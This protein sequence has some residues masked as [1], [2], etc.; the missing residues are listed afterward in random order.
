MENRFAD[1]AG[2]L[3]HDLVVDQT[4]NDPIFTKDGNRWVHLGT[5]K[6]RISYDSVNDETVHNTHIIFDEFGDIIAEFDHVNMIWLTDSDAQSLRNSAGP[7]YAFT[8][9]E[10]DAASGLYHYRARWYDAKTHQFL[11]EDPAFDDKANTYR[12]ANNDPVNHRDPS[13]NYTE[14]ELFEKYAEMYGTSG[15]ADLVASGVGYR[16]N[17]NV[18]QNVH[19]TTGR[20]K[21]NWDSM[22]QEIT[23]PGAYHWRTAR[24]V[25]DVGDAAR[26]LHSAI[27]E[28]LSYEEAARHDSMRQYKIDVAAMDLDAPDKGTSNHFFR[29]WYMTVAHVTMETVFSAPRAVEHLWVGRDLANEELSSLGRAGYAAAIVLDVTSLIPG[30]KALTSLG[31]KF[32]KG[33]ILKTMGAEALKTTLRNQAVRAATANFTQIM[34]SHTIGQLGS[35]S[36]GKKF[37]SAYAK[38]FGSLDQTIDDALVQFSPDDIADDALRLVLNSQTEGAG[39]SLRRLAAEEEKGIRTAVMDQLQNGTNFSKSVARRLRSGQIRY[40]FV[41]DLPSGV[42]GRYIE[43]SHVIKLN[44]NLAWVDQADKLASTLVHEARHLADDSSGLLGRIIRSKGYGVALERGEFRAHAE[45]LFFELGRGRG[46]FYSS[47]N[48]GWSLQGGPHAI[49]RKILSRYFF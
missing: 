17:L 8:G 11:S 49:I 24:G 22:N 42:A 26:M 2:S 23:I 48:E 31:S 44:S 39:G 20:Y 41:D 7:S 6:D 10:Y 25:V 4:V 34:G 30:A 29:S 46:E 16:W 5:V 37:L 43:G 47:W 3:G 35:S 36:V 21:I 1:D 33:V 14:A 45:Q 13:G 18:G 15:A 12:Y 27:G 38:T 9:R 40:R 32:A 19:S 28:V